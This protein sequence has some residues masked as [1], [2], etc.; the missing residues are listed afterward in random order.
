MDMFK[1]WLLSVTGMALM[2]AA[3]DGICPEGAAKRAVRLIG[4]LVLLIVV[5]K[6]LM[7]E[8]ENVGKT[9][10]LAEYKSMA[11]ETAAQAGEERDKLIEELIAENT[12]AY[13]VDKA[14]KSGVECQAQVCCERGADGLPIPAE[15][16]ISGR[17]SQQQQEELSRIIEEDLGIGKEYQSFEA[18]EGT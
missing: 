11:T 1:F 8:V 9:D 14:A 5:L 4:G 6:P 17:I 15:V 16:R 12:A 13:I 18:E 10:L 2:I 3:A 7:G